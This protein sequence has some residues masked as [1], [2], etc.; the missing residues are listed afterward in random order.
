MIRLDN[1][2]KILLIAEKDIKPGD[3]LYYDYNA[4]NNGS[5]PTE[6]FV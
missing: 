2:R 1:E 4:G 3:T 5:Y 6:H